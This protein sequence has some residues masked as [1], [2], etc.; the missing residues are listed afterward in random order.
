VEGEARVRI[1]QLD[2]RSKYLLDGGAMSDGTPDRH[3]HTWLVR[4][5]SGTVL[6][7]RA[8]HQRAGTVTSS[9]TLR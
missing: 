6:S 1:G 7:L 8:S 2:G 3:L 4:A 5:P 9:I